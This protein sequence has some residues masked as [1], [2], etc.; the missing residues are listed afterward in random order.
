MA[1]EARPAEACE[2]ITEDPS[3]IDGEAV[4]KAVVD[5]HR[6]V[7]E[8]LIKERRARAQTS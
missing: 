3:G 7:M 2:L 4:R 6:G 8:T 5:V 1:K